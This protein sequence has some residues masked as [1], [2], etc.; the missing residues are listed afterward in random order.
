MKKRLIIVITIVLALG[1]IAGA[2][3]AIHAAK[4]KNNEIPKF[5]VF[6][7][8]DEPSIEARL[9][10]IDDPA[11]KDAARALKANAAK[12]IV[13]DFLGI[14]NSDLSSPNFPNYY[15]GMYIICND[16]SGIDAPYLDDGTDEQLKLCI[17]IVKG[18]ES[19]AQELI[20]QL[21]E[22]KDFIV[23]KYTDHSYNEIREF[24]DKVLS[25]ALAEEDI[26]SDYS[27]STSGS[28]GAI[29]IIADQKD[30]KLIRRVVEPLAKEYNMIIILELVE[31]FDIQLD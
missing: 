29:R 31:D 26:S 1:I 13:N 7:N 8:N 3:A 11:G 6:A 15:T 24:R 22:Y 18:R 10:G 17:M 12:E 4:L 20:D 19:E 23:Y 30:Y 16:E 27:I 21:G 28:L 2:A 14:E 5:V 9:N 25:T